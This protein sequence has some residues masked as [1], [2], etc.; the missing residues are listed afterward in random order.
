MNNYEVGMIGEEAVAIYLDRIGC[1]IVQRNYRTNR[2]EIDI[3][4]I[5]G[6]YLVFGEVKTRTNTYFGNPA[7]AVDS[8][9]MS[10]IIG[11]AKNYVSTKQ[12]FDY[13]VRFDVFEVYYNNKKIRH[14]RNAY[15]LGGS[16]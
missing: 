4:F 2:G 6:D 15:S 1:S 7:Q 9:K 8:K 14:I 12:T 10:R 13:M 11:L 3:I 16:L 5:E